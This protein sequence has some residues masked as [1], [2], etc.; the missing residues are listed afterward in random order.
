MG[1][2]IGVDSQ[3]GRGSEFWFTLELERSRVDPVRASNQI[4]QLDGLRVLLLDDHETNLEILETHCRSWH[5]L[6][7]RTASIIAAE[8]ALEQHPCPFDV[9][10]LDMHLPDGNGLELARAIRN[11]PDTDDLKIILLS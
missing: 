4:P 5:M 7:T 6:P 8:R 3:L 9:A 2:S 10:I 11:R 1:G